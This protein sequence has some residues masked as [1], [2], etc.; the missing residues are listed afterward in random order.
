MGTSCELHAWDG[1][2]A[3]CPYC[4]KRGVGGQKEE[5]KSAKKEKKTDSEVGKPKKRGRP[6]KVT[7]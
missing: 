6:K 7:S 3:E 1:P 5:V 2:E 4:L